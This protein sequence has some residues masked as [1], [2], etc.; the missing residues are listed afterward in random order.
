LSPYQRSGSNVRVALVA[1]DPSKQWLA[2]LTEPFSR[3]EVQF[4][5]EADIE[6]ARQWVMRN[7]ADAST[8]RSLAG[9]KRGN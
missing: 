7:E 5:N 4:Y 8:S 3:A 2:T 1:R 6:S 9:G